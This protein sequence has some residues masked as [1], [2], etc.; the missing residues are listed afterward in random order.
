LCVNSGAILNLQ[1]FSSCIHFIGTGILSSSCLSSLTS[2]ITGN[3]SVKDHNSAVTLSGTTIS[4]DTYYSGTTITST[5]VTLQGTGTDVVY[6][7]SS[8]VT[9]NG[10]FSVPIGV[11]FEIKKSSTSCTY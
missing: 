7:A 8:D 2:V 10:S 4:S 11:S 3:G 1:D 6:D 5:N 9:I